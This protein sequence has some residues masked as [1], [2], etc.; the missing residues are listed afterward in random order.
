[1]T[2]E[3]V[4]NRTVPVPAWRAIAHRQTWREF[5]YLNLQMLI[6]PF[7]LTWTVA[8]V[9][10]GAGLLVTV[11]GLFVPA[12]MVVASRGW[13]SMYRGSR[14]RSSPPTSS[15]RRLDAELPP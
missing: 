12:A 13:G 6:A 7:A 10:L 15:R 1:M 8:A 11:V 14:R 2:T 4:V 5:G 9:S 3:R